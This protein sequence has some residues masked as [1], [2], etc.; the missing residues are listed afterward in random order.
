MARGNI[1]RRGKS[2][3]RLKFDVDTGGERTTR[4]ATVRGSKRDA[5]RELVRLLGER[6]KGTLPD[7]SQNTLAEYLRGWL[8][9]K[10]DLS[11]HS[12]ETYAWHIERQIIPEL[13]SIELQRLKP[14]QVKAWLDG[15]RTTGSIRTGGAISGT[16][17]RAIFRT[18][19]SALAD[20]VKVELVSRNV[21][22]VVSAPSKDTEEVEILTKAE[23]AAV[24]TALEG[25]MLHP[26]ALLGLASGCRRGEL[27]ALRWS[28]VNFKENTISV[29]R[30]LEETKSGLRF[31]EP[32]S[33]C[34][35]RSISLPASTI[36]ILSNHRK[37]Q[38]ERR[39][40]LGLGRPAV[41]ALVFCDD[42]GA[43]ISPNALSVVWRRFLAAHKLPAVT[44]HS[45][46][47]SH[48]SALIAAGL[49]IVSVSRRL[50]HSKPSITLDT[51][52]H[53]FKTDDTDAADAIAK[54]LG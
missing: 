2:S 3:W 39:M 47:H 22:A 26:I 19:R 18:L 41:D 13:G 37:A 28:D 54:V 23:V 51:Y 49:D 10:H 14:S 48:A 36:G 42:A 31:K 30:S 44:F 21:A 35:R 29:E 11:P 8:L 20:A 38:L 27:L 7:P 15:L 24:L 33:A 40:R 34:G 52:S 1:T 17:A 5:E 50:G 53:L 43:P 46:R 45:L 25:H 16:M 4:Y 32:K 9:G 6:D 12:R